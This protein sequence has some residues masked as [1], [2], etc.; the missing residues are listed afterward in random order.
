MAVAASLF[1]SITIKAQA[2]PPGQPAPVTQVP[3]DPIGNISG[4]ALRAMDHKYQRLA[5]R[6]QRDNQRA[7]EQMQQRE[8]KIARRAK[9][10]DSA[11][12]AELENG[13][14]QQYGDLLTR[15]KT[16]KI[17]GAA[18]ASPKLYFPAIDSIRTSMAFLK[19][20]GP[21]RGMSASK[22][23]QATA[24]AES[25]G[26]LQ[27]Q[28]EISQELGA[29]IGQREQQLKTQLSG[30]AGPKQLLGINKHVYYYQQQ[31]AQYKD[32][33]NDKDKLEERALAT[34][35][36]TPA[37]QQF[38]QKNSAI[39]RLFPQQTVDGVVQPQAGLQSRED[40][41]KLVA[42]HLGLPKEQG[43]VGLPG[44]SGTPIPGTMVN[45]I[46]GATA[47]PMQA[48][49]SLAQDQ[50][51]TLK[52]KLSAAGNMGGGSSSMTMPEFK[53][54]GQHNKTFFERLE[55]GFNVSSGPATNFLPVTLQPSIYAGYRFSDK[56]TAGIGAAYIL[57]M[58]QSFR[59]FR[60]SNQ[61][62]GL[63]SYLDIKLKGSFWMTGGFEYNYLQEFADLQTIKNLDAWRKSALAG[64]IKKYT[65]GKKEGKLQLL[66]D[67]LYAKELPKGQPIVYR[68]G[69]SF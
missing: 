30:Y 24:L 5:D 62:V 31:V 4:K 39:A 48:Q 21:I 59:H 57:G 54:D 36:Q 69:Y 14:S 45:P 1:L 9:K 23:Q 56:M 27:Q 19:A 58:G 41:Q 13:M 60:L 28:L 35:Q 10:K 12:A 8:T 66:F 42:D 17:N 15:I 40:I 11:R 3:N 20:A 44:A 55:T 46:P 7:L 47:N 33:L 25:T 2:L 6:L 49:V 63:R 52:N 38:W 68:V 67:L 34:L 18:A 37:F 22:L 53:P 29:F 50:L 26:R 51:N 32:M 64:I 65:I 16:A 43:T 61:G